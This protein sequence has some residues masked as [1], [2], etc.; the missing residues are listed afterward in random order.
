MKRTIGFV[1]AMLLAAGSA[2]AERIDRSEALKTASEFFGGAAGRKMA[3]AK[4]D[5]TLRPAGEGRAYYA[6]NRGEG[7]GYVIVAADD[8]AAASVLGYADKGAF[9]A[10]HMPAAMRWWLDEYARQIENAPAKGARAGERAAREAIAPMVTTRWDQGAPYNALCPDVEG[11]KCY[12]GC[13]ATAMAQVMRYHRWPERGTGSHTYEWTIDEEVMGTLSVDFSQSV[14]NWAAMTDTYGA[15]STE[16]QNAAVARLMYDAGVAMNMEYTPQESGT[17]QMA[18]A[19]ALTTYFGYDKSMKMLDRTFYTTAEWEETVYGNLAA[20]MP[21]FYMGVTASSGGHAFVCDGYSDGYFHINW[22]WSGMCDGYFLLQALN[23][24]QQGTG[25]FEGGY[26]SL[27]YILT[28]CRPDK[29]GEAEPLVY[30]DNGFDTDTKEATHA[31]TVVFGGGFWYASAV[32]TDVTMGLKVAAADG[33]VTYVAGAQKTGF[34]PT[35]TIDAYSVGLADFPTAAG[36]YTVT[37]ACRADATGKWYD[38]RTPMCNNYYCLT[39]TVGQ[40]GKITFSNPEPVVYDLEVG[41]LTLKG[42]PYASGQMKVTGTLTNNGPEYYG[43]I[44]VVIAQEGALDDDDDTADDDEDGEDDGTTTM[45]QP[46]RVAVVSGGSVDFEF[47]IGV[48]AVAGDYELV[49]VTSGEQVL[50]TMPLTV[51]EAP[52]GE[53][54]LSLPSAPAIAGDG[55]VSADNI[56][57]EAQIECTSGYYAGDVYAAVFPYFE[58]GSVSSVGLFQTELYIGEGET[59]T[60]SIHGILPTA[61]VGDRYT[62]VLYWMKDGRLEKIAS[63]NNRL[64]FTIGALTPVEG[65]E[66]DGPHDIEVYTTAGVRVLRQT[67]DEADLSALRPGLYIV[68]ENG[69]TRKV[70]KR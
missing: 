16:E 57:V 35:E 66:A 19:Y 56:S 9:S 12:T 65:V 38:V 2:M 49:L 55:L 68:K 37:P 48:P 53:T 25:G 44:M 46:E 36:T 58:S 20:G 30:C 43:D 29:G 23:P 52:A 4:G 51:T 28:D 59:Q 26:N 31:S 64:D 34:K 54:A 7:S 11:E 40:D 3:P 61:Q 5:A 62:M 41:S 70:V 15:E 17:D 60:V 69:K 24:E 42:R 32:F 21:V 39:A 1:A 8:R 33:T 67:A 27:Q 47:S 6:F 18:P 13:A 22:G 45:S 63:A 10:E 50:A 14:Y